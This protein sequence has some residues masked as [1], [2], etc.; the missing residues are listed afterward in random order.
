MTRDYLGMVKPKPEDRQDHG[1]KGMKWGVRRSSAQLKADGPKQGDSK[2]SDNKNAGV[3]AASG[4]ETSGARYARLAAQAK[5]QGAESLSDTDIKFFNARTDA[6]LKINKMNEKKPGWLHGTTKTV[7]QQTA[8]KQMQALA[9]GIASKYISTPLL[10]AL[11]G[12][13]EP[14]AAAAAKTAGT[15]K[16]PHFKL[17]TIKGTNVF[18]TNKYLRDNPDLTPKEVEMVRVKAALGLLDGK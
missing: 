18:D 12:S 4:E 2:G 11:K 13:A 3:K 7:L 17:P 15:T 14:V 6:V 1:V 9:D 16:P 10:S 8:Q 5:A